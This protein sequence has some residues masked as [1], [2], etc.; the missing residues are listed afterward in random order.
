MVKGTGRGG[1]EAWEGWAFR[2]S[3]GGGGGGQGRGCPG[4]GRDYRLSAVRWERDSQGGP[5]RRR[6]LRSWLAVPPGT[7]VCCAGGQ[8]LRDPSYLFHIPRT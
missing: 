4:W 1:A 6:P 8:L 5:T 2:G 7:P 3:A